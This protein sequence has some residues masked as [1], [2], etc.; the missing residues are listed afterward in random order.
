MCPLFKMKIKNSFVFARDVR[1]E[2]SVQS[3]YLNIIITA[4]VDKKK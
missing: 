2:I 1:V 3:D 4:V